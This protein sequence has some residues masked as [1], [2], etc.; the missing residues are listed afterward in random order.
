MATT[1]SKQKRKRFLTRL[2]WKRQREM[3]KAQMLKEA[4]ERK[5]GKKE[6]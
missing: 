1:K 6:D 2:K 5:A 4:S 3:K